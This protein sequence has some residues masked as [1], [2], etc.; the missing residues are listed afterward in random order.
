MASDNGTQT[1]SYKYSDV[2]TAEKMSKV[3]RSARP[4]GIYSG[5]I[6]SFSG[7]DA[8]VS[9]CSFEIRDTA[10]DLTDQI[11]VDTAATASVTVSGPAGTYYIVWRWSRSDTTDNYV[12]L[13]AVSSVG[14]GDVV[15]GSVYFN[16]ST[17]TTSYYTTRSQAAVPELDMKVV[18]DPAGGLYIYV[19]A[20]R[21]AT[22]GA[23]TASYFQ[24]VGPL[25][26]SNTT[27]VYINDSGVVATS[28]S[29]S[30]TETGLKLASVVCGGS[31]VTSITD[32]RSF[33]GMRLI[34]ATSAEVLTGVDNV[35]YV[36][37]AACKDSVVRLTG[38]QTVAGIKTF[39]SSPIIPM[40]TLPGQAMRFDE[41][42]RL[43]GNQTVAGIK[44]FSSSP[45]VPDATLATQAAAFGQIISKVMPSFTGGTSFSGTQLS[46]AFAGKEGEVTL[47]SLQLKWGQVYF[48]DGYGEHASFSRDFITPFST[49][50]VSVVFTA[51]NKIAD[52]PAHAVIQLYNAQV[53][54]FVAFVNNEAIVAGN[55][56]HWMAIG[57]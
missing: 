15:V 32:E 56:F 39:S 44:T 52:N 13:L 17:I 45:V 55:G 11:S 41:T 33:H 23:T 14:A 42:V 47:G 20:G 38:D 54:N 31:S 3:G 10:G 53:N 21:S 48:S 34:P 7:A 26:A 5:G 12:E 37:P 24:R 29:G 19:M 9:A 1:L 36:T 2:L 18:N 40:A 50:V 4:V 16:G 35:K 30:Y 8:Y 25:T 43:T 6:L 46:K 57:Y 51:W 22:S 27:T 49:A 28:L